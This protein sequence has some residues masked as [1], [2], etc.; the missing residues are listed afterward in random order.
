M[1]YRLVLE[2]DE[3]AEVQTSVV[4]D[5]LRSVRLTG[6]LYFEAQL[7]APWGIHIGDS[8]FANFHL[9]T[10]GSCWLSVPG[11]QWTELGRGEAVV[12][13]HGA[14]HSLCH[15]PGDD[16]VDGRDLFDR[17][18][19]DGVARIGGQGPQTTIVCGHFAYDRELS[20]PLL[21]SLP[22]IVHT[23]AADNP[24][25]INLAQLAVARSRG[26]RPGAQALTDRLAEVLLIELIA[27]LDQQRS[28][29]VRAL[30]D[31][32]VASALHAL[33][34]DPARDWT[35]E[36]LAHHVAASRSALAARFREL[37]GESPIRYLTRW[38]IHRAAELLRETTLST[39]RIAELVGYSTP[40]SLTKAFTRELGAPPA[41][42]RQ[43]RGADTA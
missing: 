39:A 21:Q 5:V 20:H 23:N 6:T 16:V 25:W 2:Q 41:T 9:V 22:A 28:G 13:P 10:S 24:G 30:S 1:G 14:T 29:F 15:Q 17:L 11:N 32:V 42:Y 12:F 7:T 37:V 43:Q 38:R 3:A 8:G 35:V 40:F 31:P 34:D 26:L 33:H 36:V 4:G 27:D 18:D 19:D